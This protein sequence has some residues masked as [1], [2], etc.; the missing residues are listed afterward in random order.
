[1]PA[2]KSVAAAE[3]PAGKFDLVKAILTVLLAASLICLAVVWLQYAGV[4]RELASLQDPVAQQAKMKAETQA[5]VAK[6]GQLMVLPAGEPTVATVI[7][8]A[9]LAQ[10]QSFFKDAK[11][12]DKVLIYKDKAIIYDPAANQIVNVGPVLAAADQLSGAATNTLP[13]SI[14]VRNGSRIIGAANDLGDKL[15]AAGFN[16][17]VVGNAASADYQA[18]VLVNLTGKDVKV[19]EAQLNLTATDKLPSGEAS[20][21]QDVVIILGNKK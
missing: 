9:K 2:K 4:K 7:D 12:G 20:S 18:T 19:L 10:E 15:K 14:E 11:N 17:A 6:V 16:V 13:I 3:V 21:S 5:L 8:S 1:M